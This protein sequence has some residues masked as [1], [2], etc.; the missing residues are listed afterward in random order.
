MGWNLNLQTTMQSGFPV[1]I[2]QSTLNSNLSTSVR[3]PNAT[4]ATSGRLENRLL[5]YRFHLRQR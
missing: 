2:G 5:H 1:A 3:R 4:P